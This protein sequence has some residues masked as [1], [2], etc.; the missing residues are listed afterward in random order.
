MQLS[1]TPDLGPWRRM[2][3][4]AVAA[5]V[6][7]MV[8]LALREIQDLPYRLGDTDD[9]MRIVMMRSLLAGPGW[10]GG[11]ALM[12]SVFRLALSPAA[13]ELATRFTWPM[14]WIV[15]VAVAST[16]VARRLGGG[17]AV[18]AC[19]I[20]MAIDMPLF[21]Q[22]RPGRVDHHNAQIAMCMLSL[23]GAA[24]RRTRGAALA[25]FA[26][27]LGIAIGLEA[28]IFEVLVGAY[29]ALR[30]LMGDEQDTRSLRAYAAALGLATVGFFLVQTPPW[31]WSVVACDAVAFNLVA[32]IAVASVGLVA[33][34][35][36]TRR[37]DWRVRLGA[38]ALVGAVTLALYVGLD[39]NCLGGPF[40]DVDPQLKVFW[41]PNVQEIRPVTRVWR[42]D[43]DTV[44]TLL[45]PMLWG[46]LAWAWLAW[47]GPR[48]QDGFLILAGACLLLGSVA[49]WNA[50][51]MAG[52]ANWF[53]TPIIAAAV[54]ALVERYGK[55]AMLITAAAACAAA[56]VFAGSAAQTVDK[57]VKIL[58]AKP[59]KPA[60][61]PPAGAAPAK[62]VAKPAA[63]S[64]AH[65]VAG[66][67]C[68]HIAAY[69]D[70][71]K[72]PAGLVLS[73]ID[74]GPFVLAH[75]PSSS[76]TAP[77]HRMSWGLIQARAALSLPADKAGDA[78]RKLGA[79]YVLECP[80]HGR[81]SDRVGMIADSL[82]KR[83]DR[84]QPPAWLEQVPSPSIL[85]LYRVRPSAAAPAAP[86]SAK[87]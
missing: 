26:T 12:D 18:L 33:A 51:R 8:I 29:F 80:P 83:L 67:R 10:F 63:K 45:A 86:V 74:L 84:N 41:L 43:H 2:V 48:R 23:A 27:G 69:A 31:R 3:P 64:T 68:F 22:F 36:L 30:Y 72:Q 71:A 11:L 61:K 24:M 21:L 19:A 62:P 54:T 52:Y 14:L 85:R 49:G 42:T 53:A 4:A 59:A 6:I 76:M 65:V 17:A 16:T 40:A 75:T 87:P 46:A 34:V 39:R 25:G 47:K 70:L 57:Q 56:P 50:I 79:T 5:A 7:A 55:G 13:A 28:L 78:A 66:D 81:N 35:A 44:Y 58:T 60:P 15:P 20:L 82:Q 38:L 1:R 9:A 37:H 32:A 77:Y 73:E